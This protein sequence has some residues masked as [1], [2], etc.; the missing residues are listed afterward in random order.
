MNKSY[1]FRGHVAEAV[2]TL[3]ISEDDYRSRLQ[4]I[5]LT[6]PYFFDFSFDISAAGIIFTFLLYLLH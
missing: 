3:Q 4:A 6:E 5:R 1:G 2:K